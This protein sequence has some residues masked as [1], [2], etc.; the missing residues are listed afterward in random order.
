MSQPL[1][2]PVCVPVVTVSKDTTQSAFKPVNESLLLEPTL[3]RSKSS[4]GSSKK[5]RM[6]SS[7]FRSYDTD[8]SC[9]DVDQTELRHSDDEVVRLCHSRGTKYLEPLG[10]D[11]PFPAMVN[12]EMLS[13]LVRR[14]FNQTE[15]QQIQ[16]E[17]I[18]RHENGRKSKGEVWHDSY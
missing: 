4:R 13:S 7:S 17:Q 11:Q 16:Y 18:L 12:R 6:R 5:H 15:E 1:E 9:D 14:S 8:E 10:R 2:E 3:T